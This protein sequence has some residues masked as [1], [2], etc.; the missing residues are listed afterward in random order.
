MVADAC[1]HAASRTSHSTVAGVAMRR[2]TCVRAAPGLAEASR[3]GL[4]CE[5]RAVV[6][7]AMTSHDC[8]AAMRFMV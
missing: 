3:A 2:Y 1:T 6:G 7:G 4:T 8:V 5:C